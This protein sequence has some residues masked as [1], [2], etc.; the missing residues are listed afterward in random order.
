[1]DSPTNLIPG[2]FDSAYAD[3]VEKLY[4]GRL[5]EEKTKVLV[6][7]SIWAQCKD[8]NFFASITEAPVSLSRQDTIPL[9]DILNL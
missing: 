3:T 5:L 6:F 1:M 9:E 4:P 2:H 8:L 7:Q